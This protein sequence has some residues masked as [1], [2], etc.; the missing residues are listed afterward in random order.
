MTA[1]ERFM[2]RCL[3]L[4]TEAVEAGDHPFGAV[5]VDAGGEIMFEGRNR[6]I[7][8][9]DVSWHAEMEVLRKAT[10]ALKTNSLEGTTLYTNGEPC[11]MCSVVIRKAGVS[12]VVFGAPSAAPQ[13]VTPHPLTDS[14]FDDGTPPSVIGGLLKED[15]LRVQGR[16]AAEE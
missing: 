15:S 9:H 8:A 11:L 2:R 16:S 6:E 12:R 4:A 5:L 1:D 3:E 10:S 7:T 13:R 14:D